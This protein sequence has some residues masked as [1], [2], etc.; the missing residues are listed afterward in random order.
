M[1][2]IY[3]I[4]YFENGYLVKEIN[5]YGFS[6][7]K[8]IYTG[9][10]RWIILNLR[11]L[12]YKNNI[13][14]NKLLPV[15][16]D[17]PFI[18]L[19]NNFDSYKINYQLNKK[20]ILLVFTDSIGDYIIW[21]NFI[22]E[23]KKSDKYK[24]YSL[25]IIACRT[26]KNFIEYLD[27]DKF[28]KIFYVPGRFENLSSKKISSIRQEFDSEGLESYYDTIIYCSVNA[29]RD[30][31]IK[32]EQFITK[33]IHYKHS[34]IH[35]NSLYNMDPVT[36]LKFTMVY[37]N[38]NDSY[39]HDFERAKNFW[40][41]VLEKDFSFN[42]PFIDIQASP[43]IKKD[44]QYIVINPCGYDAY[45][46]W[47]RNNW[48][49]LIDWL[50]SQNLE[51]ILVCTEKEKDFCLTIRE[52]CTCSVDILA[53]LPVEQLLN[54]LKNA[55]LYIGADSGIF[56]VAAALG[57][58]SIA[59]SAGSSFFRFMNYPKERK[60]IRILF[61]EGVEAW[62]WEHKEAHPDDNISHFSINSILVSDV[63]K[64]CI[65]LID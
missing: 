17:Y 5:I 4:T 6:I 63:K 16:Y 38:Y 29:S 32:A 9:R 37:R 7:K 31:K 64:V 48:S 62:I 51:V 33:N 42:H 52:L 2:K 65:S 49:E 18:T 8:R 23:I 24:D 1:K 40:S 35:Y 10:T 27:K 43:C 15:G 45:R 36:L 34:I 20:N 13:V 55:A 44:K 54:L 22:S 39:L 50:E 46:C 11:I 3:N 25:S 21:R 58:N 28:I 41:H 53:D 19:K 47:H 60:N 14:P 26:Y 61:P 30:D 56:H 12:S 57:T 59:L